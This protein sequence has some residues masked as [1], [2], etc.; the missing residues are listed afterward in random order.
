MSPHHRGPYHIHKSNCTGT[1]LKAD[2][3]IIGW[4]NGHTPSVRI[5]QLRSSS[6]DVISTEGFAKKKKKKVKNQ[7]GGGIK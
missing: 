5:I 3:G 1:Y 2:R 6:C 7:A 4:K